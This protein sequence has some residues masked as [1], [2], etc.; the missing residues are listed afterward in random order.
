MSM[1]DQPISSVRRR[2]FPFSGFSLFRCERFGVSPPQETN[3][4]LGR[5]RLPR[6]LLPYLLKG[7]K[8]REGERGEPGKSGKALRH[9]LQRAAVPP[10]SGY[11]VTSKKT[12]CSNLWLGYYVCVGVP[13]AATTSSATP[14]PT[15]SCP[16]PQMPNIVSNCK[17]CRLV[18]S[19]DT[20]DVIDRA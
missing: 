4:K 7:E 20:C 17:K 13:G 11:P 14:T 15:P 8:G 19:G 1:S 12:A 2:R 18:Q 6:L 9:R 3:K 16:Q 10:R 5:G